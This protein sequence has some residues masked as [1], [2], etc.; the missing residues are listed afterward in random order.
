MND[1]GMGRPERAARPMF[2]IELIRGSSW[3]E[4]VETIDRRQ[5]HTDSLEFALGEALHWLREIQQA[6]PTRGVTHYRIVGQS[7]AV[8]GGPP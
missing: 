5:C 2:T 7:G 3:Q 8:I 1:D 6:T 4:P